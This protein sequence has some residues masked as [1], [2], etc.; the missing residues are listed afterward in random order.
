MYIILSEHYHCQKVVFY[1]SC[2]ILL[3]EITSFTNMT[4]ALDKY[5][6]FDVRKDHIQEKI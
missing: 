5:M 3:G 4:F 6:T 1:K 2:F